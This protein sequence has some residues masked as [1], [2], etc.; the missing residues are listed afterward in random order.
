[1]QQAD[2]SVARMMRRGADAD[3]MKA[4][5]RCAAALGRLRVLVHV[6]SVWT[7]GRSEAGDASPHG[8]RAPDRRQAMGVVS[9]TLPSTRTQS[10]E[11]RDFIVKLSRCIMSLPYN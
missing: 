10:S 9:D 6:M 3:E 5:A 7:R 2:D 4:G 11:F 1:M 8:M